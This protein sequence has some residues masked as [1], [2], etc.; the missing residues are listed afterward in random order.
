MSAGPLP[1]RRANGRAG[2]QAVLWDLDDTLLDSLALRMK[3]LAHACEVCVGGRVDPLDLWRSTR[4]GTL[5]ALGQRLLGDDYRRFVSVYRDRYYGGRHEIPRPFDG[6]VTALEGLHQRGIA[7]AVVTS[8]VSWGATDELSGAGILAYFA[9]V[10]GFDD[11][12]QHKPDAEPV[13][14]AMDRLLVTEPGSVAFVGDSPAD[15]F[16]ARNAGC[17]AIGALWGTLDSSVLREAAPEFAAE[18]PGH[19]LEWVVN[20]GR[21]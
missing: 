9:A 2:L 1:A 4:G 18:R 12:E 19:V 20:G 6:V 3:A 21:P 7:M 13:F 10:V 8:K 17:G 15:V 14:A 16:A 5:E 11:T